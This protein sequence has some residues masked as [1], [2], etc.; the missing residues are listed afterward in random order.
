MGDEE[1]YLFF[2]I[3]E[4][5]IILLKRNKCMYKTGKKIEENKIQEGKRKKKP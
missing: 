3:R 2:L 4:E 1:N 5:R